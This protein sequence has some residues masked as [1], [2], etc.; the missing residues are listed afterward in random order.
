MVLI[1]SMKI[2]SKNIFDV[3]FYA[4]MSL[5]ALSLFLTSFIQGFILQ[6][7]D[8]NLIG[9]FWHYFGSL[10][11]LITASFIFMRAKR[12]ITILSRSDFIE[13]FLRN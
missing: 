5:V 12:V 4:V 7:I 11:A 1:Q 9:A 2:L 6:V 8:G 13:Q 3:I 10:L